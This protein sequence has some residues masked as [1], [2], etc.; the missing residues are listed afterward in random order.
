MAGKFNTYKSIHKGVA[1]ILFTAVY[2]LFSAE[3]C[4]SSP[5]DKPR[6]GI[7][8]EYIATPQVK[9]TNKIEEISDAEGEANDFSQLH[10][11]QDDLA[12]DSA[13]DD[14]SFDT[15]TTTPSVEP[16]E[17]SVAKDESKASVVDTTSKQEQKKEGS[18]RGVDDL[19]P[20]PDV[21]VKD[22]CSETPID[23]KVLPERPERRRSKS[24]SR[25]IKS[26]EHILNLLHT[27]SD[28]NKLVTS[29]LLNSEVK[30]QRPKRRRHKST[31]PVRVEKDSSNSRLSS[32]QSSDANT[33]VP[34]PPP[35]LPSEDN[36][37]PSSKSSLLSSSPNGT[38]DKNESDGSPNQDPRADL[39]EEIRGGVKL[40]KVPQQEGAR[41][42]VVQPEQNSLAAALE[43]AL[44]ER[45]KAMHSE[46]ESDSGSESEH[47]DEWNG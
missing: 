7:G 30:P 41:N 27:L 14:E 9:Q 12:I 33:F 29:L 19:R 38:V 5:K 39:L 46:S 3:I 35:P 2:L 34:P 26:S 20:S 16:S 13:Q 28:T 45:N 32:N 15:D 31:L 37:R 36:S 11:V 22:E 43:R 25:S 17:D 18:T 47:D 42:P 1:N 23:S 8:N 21:L 6:N 44:N 4:S 24:K 40:R 10:E